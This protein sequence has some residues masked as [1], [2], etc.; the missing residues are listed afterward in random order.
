MVSGV[1]L[2]EVRMKNPI[3][4]LREEKGL[5]QRDLAILLEVSAALIS[6][7]EVGAL[8]PSERMLHRIANIFQINVERLDRELVSFYEERKEEVKQKLG[9]RA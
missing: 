2:K 1:F 5:T 9:L 8:A 6:Q 3:T 7:L 4:K